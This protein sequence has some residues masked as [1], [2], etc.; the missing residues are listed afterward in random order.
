MT[1]KRKLIEVALPLEAINVACKADKD[2]KTGNHPKPAQVVRADAVPAAGGRSSS[3][4]SSMTRAMTETAIT[5]S[6]SS[7]V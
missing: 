3:A 7:S 5:Y 2:R 6:S 4:A 1:T